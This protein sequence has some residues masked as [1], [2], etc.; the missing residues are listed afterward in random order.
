MKQQSKK[1]VFFVILLAIFVIGGS[2]LGVSALFFSG[3]PAPTSTL[4]VDSFPKAQVFVNE[5]MV[6]E[7]P[8]RQEKM[9]PGEILLRLVGVGQENLI[10]ESK[11]KLS[12]NI[13][14]F[15][16]RDLAQTQDESSGQVLILERAASEKSTGISVISTPDQA[17]VMV[18]EKDKGQTPIIIN[19]VTAG[20]H[21]IVVSASGYAD[22]VI[23]GKISPGF[24]LRVDVKLKKLPAGANNLEVDNSRIRPT[25]ELISSSSAVLGLTKPY[26]TVKD[27]P[28]GF[29]RVRFAPSITST[30]SGK[31]YPGQQYSLMEELDQWVRVK[32]GT[33][34]GWVADSYVE[35][36][37]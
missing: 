10:W 14:T 20:D 36:T 12:E 34:S 33:S 16:S 4:Q 29:L 28:T 15:V 13:L 37:K 26:I 22:Q 2:F 27:T 9:P 18:D 11:I 25:S 21:V 6:G 23:R 1:R 17:S 35:K 30:E 19:G 3:G 31:V 32:I 8:F 7:T 5:K 24:K